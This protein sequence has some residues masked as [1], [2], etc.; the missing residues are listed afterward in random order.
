MSAALCPVCHRIIHP[1]SRGNVFRHL[2]KAGNHCP[3]SGHEF[4]ETVWTE[5]LTRKA[6]TGRSGG[7][8]EWCHRARATDKHHRIN[9]SQGGGWHPANIVDLCRECHHAV[10]VNPQWAKEIGLSIEPGTASPA[11]VPIQRGDGDLYL[12]DDL[13]AQAGARA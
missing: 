12:T 5:K 4:P 7:V 1:T 6:V 8:C 13:I 10:T 3:M 11:E 2:D 9:Q